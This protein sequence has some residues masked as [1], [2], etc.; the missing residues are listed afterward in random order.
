M[1]KPIHQDAI[2]FQLLLLLK[3]QHGK[4]GQAI[5]QNEAA[6]YLAERFQVATIEDGNTGKNEAAPSTDW[7]AQVRLACAHLRKLRYITKH[8]KQLSLTDAGLNMLVFLLP[9]VPT[10]IES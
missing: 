7:N 4:Q 3:S 8:P 9:Q 2:A 5:S 10:H 1:L 6:D